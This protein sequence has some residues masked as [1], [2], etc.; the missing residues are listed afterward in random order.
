MVKSLISIGY[1]TYLYKDSTQ[2]LG[3]WKD[4]QREGVGK[5]IGK[6]GE[7]IYEGLFVNNLQATEGKPNYLMYAHYED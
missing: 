1:G 7:V 4:G 6:K 5:L 3:Q 2:Y